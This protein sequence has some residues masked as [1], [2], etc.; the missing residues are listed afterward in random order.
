MQA[1]AGAT[2]TTGAAAHAAAVLAAPP[3]DETRWRGGGGGGG[4]H[5][6]RHQPPPTTVPRVGRQFLG[7]VGAVDGHTR[8][9]PVDRLSALG[10]DAGAA[11]RGTTSMAPP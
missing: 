10:G 2:T 4:A 5:C 3:R 9:V 6:S 7:Q 1:A 11:T 8:G